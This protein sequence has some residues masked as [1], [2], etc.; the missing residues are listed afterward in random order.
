MQVRTCRNCPY[1]PTDLGPHFSAHA[2]E[3]CCLDCQIA[4][5]VSDRVYPRRRPKSAF[6]PKPQELS[7]AAEIAREA[8][9]AR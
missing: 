1:A 2:Q 7:A 9:V 3:L 5:P 8:A 6:V 4:K